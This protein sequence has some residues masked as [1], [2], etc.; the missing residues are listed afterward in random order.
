MGH[1][2]LVDGGKAT[3]TFEFEQVIT[4]GIGYINYDDADG[5]YHAALDLRPAPRHE[6]LF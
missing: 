5:E 1:D 3:L 4:K 2:D 6:N